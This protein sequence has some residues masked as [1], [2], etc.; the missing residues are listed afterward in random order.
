MAH[1]VADAH[2]EEDARAP[3]L[4]AILALG[5]AHSVEQRL[6]EPSLVSETMLPLSPAWKQTLP[7]L[8]Q[9]IVEAAHPCRPVLEALTGL[10]P[11]P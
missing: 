1:V 9:F 3:L 10:L 5:R 2:L 8:R 4:E 11:A 7:L 6:L